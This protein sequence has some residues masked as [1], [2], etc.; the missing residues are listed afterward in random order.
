MSP[1]G[2]REATDL[3]IARERHSGRELRAAYVACWQDNAA[4]KA[5]DAEDL[6]TK[7]QAH[8]GVGLSPDWFLEQADRDDAQAAAWREAAERMAATITQGGQP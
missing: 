8:P 7:A 2:I 4:T 6:R 1:A 3:V 5:I